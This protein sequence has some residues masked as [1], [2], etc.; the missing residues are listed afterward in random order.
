[1]A[2]I[3]LR[4]KEEAV[5]LTATLQNTAESTENRLA[6]CDAVLA[7]TKSDAACAILCSAGGIHAVINALKTATE[8]EAL[9]KGTV[10]TLRNLYR[11]DSKLTSIVVRLQEGIGAMLEGLREHIHCSDPELLLALLTI[12]SDVAHNAA[13]VQV[14][15]KENGTAVIL[16]SVLAHLK[17]DT[18]LLPALNLLVAISRHPAHIA[19]L[20][21]EGGVPAV[22]AAIL[23]H[24]RRVEVLKAALI[25]LRNIVA[26]DHS[27]MRLGGQGAYRIVFA[28]LQTHSSVEQLELVRLGAAVLWRIHHARCPPTSLLHS[29]LA[30]EVTLDHTGLAAGH[31]DER[32]LCNSSSPI[33]T[34]PLGGANGGSR[35]SLLSQAK[36]RA[37]GS[38]GVGGGE[39][40]EEADPLDDEAGDSD[41]GGVDEEEEVSGNGAAKA[42]LVRA[43]GGSQNGSTHNGS[44]VGGG[45]AEAPAVADDRPPTIP[46]AQFR[47]GGHAD[48]LDTCPK[49]AEGL[50]ASSLPAT[51]ADLV[52]RSITSE[53]E[54]LMSPAATAAASSTAAASNNTADDS[55]SSTPC[56]TPADATAVGAP[57]VTYPRIVYDAYPPEGHSPHA[58]MEGGGSGGSGGQP[59]TLMFD[60][61]FES[62]NL[63]RAVQVGPYEYHLVLSCDVNTRGHT[64]WFL[65]RLRNMEANQPY[66]FH[67]INLMKP[68]SLF[69]SG[70]KPLVYSERRAGEESVGWIRAGDEIAYFQNQYTYTTAPKKE[71]AGAKKK[72]SGN[73]GGAAATAAAKLPVEQS[74]SSYYTLT[75]RLTFPHANDTIYVSQCFPYTYTMAQRLTNR[76]LQEKRSSMIRREVLCHT[77]GGNV[78]ELLTVTDFTSPPAE[79]AARRVVVISSRVHPGESNASW[80]MDGLL[81]AVTADTPEAKQLRR[82]VMLKIIPMLNPDGVILGNYRCSVVG[83][84]LNRQWLDPN[85]TNHPTIFHLKK[86][87][88]GYL[89]TDQLLLFCDFHGH[90]R[91]RNIFAYACETLKGANRLR[92]RIFPKLLADCPHFS[93]GGCSF[94]VLK[95]KETT[96]RVVVNRQFSNPNSF[97]LEASFCG[98]DFGPGAGS[99]YTIAHLKEMGAAFVPALIEFTDPQ[100]VRVAQIMTELDLQFP[101]ADGEGGGGVGDEDDEDN[102]NPYSQIDGSVGSGGGGGGGSEGATEKLRRAVKGA[103]AGGAKRPPA[104]PGNS[105][106]SGSGGGAKVVGGGVVKTASL[107]RAPGGGG[108]TSGGGKA[109]ADTKDKKKKKPGGGGVPAAAGHGGSSPRNTRSPH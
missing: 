84:D 64:Q 34:R 38:G 83:C 3:N 48:W 5:A 66:K 82:T 68:D 42:V 39:E 60:S 106:G 69:S 73:T 18:L 7:C 54:R 17:N 55:S 47:Y 59:A 9:L 6:A 1:M 37:K 72:E 58:G 61:A 79:V 105:G 31:N 74:V 28:V 80:M 103:G 45:A 65:F 12:L 76:L 85:E 62:A 92:E 50:S 86:L 20:V 13:N 90:S 46:Q 21:R 87:M 10:L 97:T 19:T 14:L 2:T 70:M 35:G 30:F 101:L 15:V 25:V 95:S 57:A 22:L 98:A 8:N 43:V 16:A 29:Q 40:E 100:Q 41:C 36:Q 75:F 32:Q 33:G 91:K 26:D 96:G 89:A 52:V 94:K 102:T 49:S 67:L 108:G 104:A 51:H 99:H 23:A 56:N 109:A 4:S 93:L 81:E 24:L 71:K 77:Y 107:T 11:F 44:E 53:A 78:C 27:A 63:R 88:K